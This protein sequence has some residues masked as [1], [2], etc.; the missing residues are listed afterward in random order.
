MRTTLKIALV[1]IVALAVGAAASTPA[2]AADQENQ[3]NNGRAEAV[4]KNVGGVVGAVAGG[5]AGE[6]VGSTPGALAG[7]AIGEKVGEAVGAA[8][9]RTLDQHAVEN[10]QTGRGGAS[11]PRYDPS[12]LFNR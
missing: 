5:T 12:T 9:G 1:G 6:A 11:D 10:Q 8:A 7:G 4:G 2:T 3:P